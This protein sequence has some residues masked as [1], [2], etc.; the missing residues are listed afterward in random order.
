MNK[1]IVTFDKSNEDIPTLIVGR[2]NF[3]SLTSGMEIVQVV[4]GDKA[5]RIWNELGGRAESEGSN[6]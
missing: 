3:F 4:T 5:I 6:E 2:E 1:Y